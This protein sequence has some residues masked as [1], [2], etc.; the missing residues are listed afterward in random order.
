MESWD[1]GTI[2]ENVAGHDAVSKIETISKIDA[3]EVK[4]FGR[5]T[6]HDVENSDISLTVCF[7]I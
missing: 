2:V 6:L 5:W 7:F 3:P 1:Q 4:I